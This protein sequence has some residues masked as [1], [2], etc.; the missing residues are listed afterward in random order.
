LVIRRRFDIESQAR[1]HAQQATAEGFAVQLR[2]DSRG[3]LEVPGLPNA[4]VAIHIGRAAQMSCSR[5][6]VSHTGSAVHGDID[7]IPTGTPSRWEMHDENDRILLMSVPLAMLHAVAEDSGHEISGIELRNRFMARDRQLENIGWAMKTEL[8]MG[9][10]SGPLY[11]DGLAV[12]AAARLVAGHS[13]ITVEAVRRGGLD[14]RRLKRTLE[15]IEAHLPEELSL[16]RLAA[17]AD[18]S[19]SHFRAAF[20]ESIGA[21]VH[22]YIIERRIEHAGS[23]LMHGDLSIAQIALSSGFTHQSHLARHM[24]RSTRLSPLQMKR[25]FAERMGVSQIL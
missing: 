24:Q 2:S 23:L 3:V 12:S 16:L 10:P 11:L 15:F 9:S 7:I 21:P 17:I 25:I 22:Q 19:V 5:G 6:G 18:M 14:G 4:L 13:S 20:R 1:V 8:D